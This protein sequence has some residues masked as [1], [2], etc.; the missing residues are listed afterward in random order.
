MRDAEPKSGPHLARPSYHNFM[1]HQQDVLLNQG[2]DYENNLLD[3]VV[4]PYMLT[5]PR[6]EYTLKTFEKMLVYLI[7]ATGNIKKA[8][9]YTVDKN[10]R[11]HS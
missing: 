9:N 1:I 4:S 3:K 7:N 11:V 6:K 2:Y 5:D 8:F 10:Y